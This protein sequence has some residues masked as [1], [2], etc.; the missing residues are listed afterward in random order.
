MVVFGQPGD[1]RATHLSRG[2]A[3]ERSAFM[4]GHCDSSAAGLARIDLL[5][6]RAD[7]RWPVWEFGSTMVQDGDRDTAVHEEDDRGVA[8][9]IPCG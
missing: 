6:E 4:A 3:A 5:T 2:A 7:R 1:N 8:Q 9:G